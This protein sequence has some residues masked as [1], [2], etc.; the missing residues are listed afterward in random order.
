MTHKNSN[1]S[2][3]AGGNT[4]SESPVNKIKVKTTFLSGEVAEWVA[5]MAVSL[6]YLCLYYFK[7][8]SNVPFPLGS[9][10]PVLQNYFYYL[11]WIISSP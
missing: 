10:V 9:P 8:T 7:G 5:T 4:V 1:K 11:W 3:Q 2:W 6:H